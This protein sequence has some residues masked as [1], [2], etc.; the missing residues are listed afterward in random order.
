MPPG[1][2]WVPEGTLDGR[3]PIRDNYTSASGNWSARSN[4]TDGAQLTM[5]QAGVYGQ[6]LGRG[7]RLD[8]APALITRSLRGTEV[9]VT[10]TRNDEPEPGLSGALPSVDAYLVS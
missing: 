3:W 4:S 8:D 2:S 9:A 5:T 6:R 1:Q 10:E 7:L